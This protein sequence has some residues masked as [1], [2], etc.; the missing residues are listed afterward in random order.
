MSLI[1]STLKRTKDTK[2]ENRFIYLLYE[3]VVTE[4]YFIEPFI[5]YSSFF[6]KT[7]DIVFKKVVKL[8]NDKGASNIK[9]LTK[10]AKEEIVDSLPF[11]KKK[12]K[13][14]FIFDLDIYKNNYD[15]IMNIMDYCLS[16]Y[17]FGYTNPSIELFLLLT[18]KNSFNKYIKNNKTKILNNEFYK[19]NRRYINHLFYKATK[20]NS[21]RNKT[22]LILLSNKFD[23]AI[24]EEKKHLNRF[25]NKAYNSLTSNIGY[26][27]TKIKEDKIDEINYYSFD[28]EE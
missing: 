8:Y 9:S 12:D 19:D 13:V 10:I 7:N 28:E 26:I 18:I 17:I 5:K 2:E 20:I 27:F 11:N 14:L 1:T 21:K 6:N 16:Y 25:I 4:P 15:N 24:N 23:V 3:G 22:K